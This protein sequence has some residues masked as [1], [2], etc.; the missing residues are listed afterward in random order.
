M[1]IHFTTDKSVEL[2]SN[3]LLGKAIGVGVCGGIASVEIV[4]IIR[5][6]RRHGAE[7]TAFFTPSVEQ[8]ITPLPVE[9]ASG[10]PVVRS[11]GPL[12]E[13]FEPFDLV[14]I[15]PA[16]L[17]TISKAAAGMADNSVSMLIASQLGR[18]APLLFVPTM[19]IVL[20]NHPAYQEHKE[21]LKLWGSQFLEI[22]IE[23]GRLKVPAPE[24]VSDAVMGTLHC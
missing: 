9:W 12:V 5:D 7:V 4:K 19:N 18:K 2:K 20:A 10:R 24:V 15:A 11:L 6:L 21:K 23:E 22:A 17:N 14:L 16:T 8:F 13:H 3:R 1:A